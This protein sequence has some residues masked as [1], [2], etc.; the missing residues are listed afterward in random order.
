MGGAEGGGKGRGEGKGA[1][2]QEGGPG[3]ASYESLNSDINGFLGPYIDSCGAR[4]ASRGR[5]DEK[6]L[7]GDG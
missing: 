4:E 2:G 6:R 5:Q 3:A 1:G 7:D